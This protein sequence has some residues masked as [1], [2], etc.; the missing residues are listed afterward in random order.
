VAG[1]LADLGV[2]AP[3]DAP[4]GVEVTRRERAGRGYT[5]VLNHTPQPARIPLPAP[6]QDL[7]TGQ[8][9]TQSLL[10]APLDVAIL[11]T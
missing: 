3:L 4:P 6:M 9:H 7:L 5:F 2:T 8:T 10:L 11:T 1:L